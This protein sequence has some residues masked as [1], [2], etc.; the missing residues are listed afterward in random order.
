MRNVGLPSVEVAIKTTN[1]SSKRR[2][3]S[4]LNNPDHRVTTHSKIRFKILFLAP[5]ET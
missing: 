3:G 4:E 1:A 2:Y 5:C